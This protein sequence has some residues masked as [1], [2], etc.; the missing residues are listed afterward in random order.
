MYEL[1]DETLE[2]SIEVLLK[3]CKN[4]KRFSKDNNQISVG[5][6]DCSD[7]T[8]K[9]LRRS[10]AN[11]KKYLES[12][13]RNSAAAGS[14]FYCCTFEN[15]RFINANFQECSFN[16]SNILYNVENNEVISCNFNDSLFSDDFLLQNIQFKHSV[17]CN[18]AFING[19]IK[20]I[21]FSACTLEGTTFSN[22]K[23]ENVRFTDLNL[24]YSIFENIKMKN[25]ILPFSQ[26]CYVFGLLKYL[27]N[28]NDDVYISSASNSNGYISKTEFLDLMPHF[29][30]YYTDTKDF[31][32]LANIYFYLG[33][34]DKAKQTILFGIAEAIQEVDFRKIKY[35]CKLIYTYGVFNFHERQEIYNY[36]HSKITFYNMHSS[37]LYNYIVYKKE[38][39][40]YLLTNNRKE[41]ITCEIYIATNV[42]H[43]EADKLGI[44]IYTIESVVDLYQSIYGEHKIVCRHNSPESILL[45]IQDFAPIAISIATGL[46]SVLMGYHKLEE[47]RLQNKKL[48]A[49]I[50]KLN[51]EK[52]MNELDIKLKNI[53]LQN[54]QAEEKNH[55]RNSILS[56]NICQ[57]NI[58]ILDMH[59]FIYGNIPTQIDHSLV[60]NSYYK[61]NR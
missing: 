28:T 31:F 59:H 41:T 37:L 36:I 61:S 10:R 24:D 29:V 40:G 19:K 44:L 14:N 22:V 13:F 57:N 1:T 53:E 47:K 60:Q 33:E 3:H 55:T 46:Y 21:D 48:L 9:S 45:V 25:V 50:E 54:K 35:L 32:P 42:S 18:S 11:E 52:I 6:K 16:C 15:C 12:I 7:Y 30:T 58:E 2:H 5:G 26:I 43:E 34:N 51:T 20:D 8:N 4:K 27:K 39:E 56:R 49:E 17:F 23:M 38:I